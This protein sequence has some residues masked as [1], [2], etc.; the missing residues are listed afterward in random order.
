MFVCVV[1]YLALAY[2]NPFKT[3]SLISNLEPPP[4]VFYYSVPAWN[5]AHGNG[6]KLMAFDKEISQLTTPFYG[7]YLVPFFAV[8]ND[9]RSYYFA[10]IILG[11]VSIYLFLKLAELF[12]GRDKWFLYFGLGLVFVT[13]F[14]FYNLPTL[15]M[16]ENILI[17]LTLMAVILSFKKLDLKFF[18][19]NLL[20]MTMLAFSKVSSFPVILVQGVVLLVKL[21]QSKFWQKIP[22]HIFL[23]L[24]LLFVG[25]FSVSFVKIALPLIK[26]LPSVSD[27][28]SLN[29][30]SKTFP[31][32]F[33]EFFGTGGSYLWYNNQQIEK[34]VAIVSLCGLILG[35]F[36]KKFRT[37]VIIL[38]SII[39]GVTLFHSMM[40]YPEGRYISTV[41]PLFI[42]LS[43][44]VFDKLKY[45]VWIVIFLGIY[46][47][48]RGTVNGFYE[49]KATSL[50]RQALNNQ[51]EENEVPWN[52]RAIES[53]NDYFKD[54]K[55]VYLGTILNPFYIM[56]F[57][58]GNY[59]FLP[60]SPN[61]EF[62]GPGKGFIDKYL[63]KDKTIVDLYKRILNEGNDLYVTNYYLTYYKGNL[64][65]QYYSLE[66]VFKFTQV[67][68]GCLGECKLYKL[69][70]KK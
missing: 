57:G 65:G 59:K 33:K 6:F 18:I 31:V 11:V 44:I 10:N 45:P 62:S 8:V 15:L 37:K 38:V 68:D 32:Y 25:F 47:L 26:A 50:K 1:V 3:N 36:L 66:K 28:F 43:G 14:Y 56:F 55:D 21:I 19:L 34:F 29:Y 63:E 12:F 58:S 46:F 40:G 27:S 61:Q 42:L 16:A 35:L 2:K 13:N 67:K 24:F 7:I 41:I 4:D 22:R 9:V 54:K 52:Y 30:V 60:L 53:F 17:P 70:L 5:F 20:V 49:R 51:L 39:F 69:E 48:S 64:D 23:I